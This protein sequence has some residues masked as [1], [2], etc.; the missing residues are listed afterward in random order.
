MAAI[1]ELLGGIRGTVF[2]GIA[3]VLAVLL[4]I[5]LLGKQSAQDDLAKA[6]AEWAKQSLAQA[7]A[8]IAARERAERAERTYAE[9]SKAAAAEYQRGLKDGQEKATAVADSVRSGSL[10]LRK[11]WDCASDRVPDYHAAAAGPDT[12]DA[13]ELRATDSGNLVRVGSDADSL[14]VRLQSE[15]IATRAL[16]QGSP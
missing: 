10:K 7:E 16:C 5:A 12:D 6:R 14:A 2:A 15:L 8:Y 3:L 4:G 1:V 9:T 13:A 11:Q